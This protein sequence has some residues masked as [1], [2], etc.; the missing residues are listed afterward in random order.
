[1]SNIIPEDKLINTC[2]MG[3][4]GDCCRYIAATQLGIVCAK[5]DLATK[6]EIDFRVRQGLFVAVGDNCQGMEE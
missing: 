1:M 6:R 4:G 3:Q 2:K 5:H